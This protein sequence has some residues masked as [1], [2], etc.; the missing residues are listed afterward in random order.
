MIDEKITYEKI[1]SASNS[2]KAQD[3]IKPYNGPVTRSLINLSI[4]AGKYS[5]F[6]ADKLLADKFEELYTLWIKRS[7]CGLMDDAVLVFTKYGIQKGMVTLK[8]ENNIGT[9]GLI[10]VDPLLQGQGVGT[11]LILAAENYYITNNILI[12]RVSTQVH[13][14]A[15]CRFYTKMGYTLQSVQPIYHIWF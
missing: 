15:A 12:S 4:E 9:I 7:L 14:E 2:T 1:L 6:K 8:I 13:N 3:S 11:E 5:R 10:G